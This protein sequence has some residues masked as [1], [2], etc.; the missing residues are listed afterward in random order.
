[1]YRIS[2]SQREASAQ[3]TRFV[4]NWWKRKSKEDDFQFSGNRSNWFKTKQ[5]LLIPSTQSS[6]VKT[7]VKTEHSGFFSHLW[8]W[9]AVDDE[10]WLLVGLPSERMLIAMVRSSIAWVLVLH[11]EEGALRASAAQRQALLVVVE[12][13]ERRGERWATHHIHLVCLLHVSRH[14]AD[15]VLAQLLLLAGLLLVAIWILRHP[16]QVEET[17]QTQ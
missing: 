16:A 8:Q 10:V 17:E 15:V 5:T 14:Q 12:V 13:V 1:M 3:T 11:V 7:D 6:A 4:N 9:H 2:T